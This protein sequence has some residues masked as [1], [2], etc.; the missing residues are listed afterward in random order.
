MDA[1]WSL[2]WDDRFREY[3]FGPDHPFTQES[4]WLA[5]RLMEAAGVVGSSPG[6]HSP[7]PR[8]VPIASGAELERFH[9]VAYLDLVEQASHARQ[10]FPL[11]GGDTPSF[12]GCF[13]AAARVAKGTLLA[14]DSVFGEVPQA[15]NP[16]GGLHHAHP[17]RA[18]GFCIFNDLAIAIATQIRH[19]RRRIAYVDID[20]H[21]GDG[22]MYGFYDEGHVLDIDFHQDGRT[23]FPGT[24]TPQETGRGDGAGLKVNVPL[25]PGAG[26][27]TFLTLFRRLVPPLIRS[28]RPEVILL[29]NGVDAHVDDGLAALALTPV[30]YTEVITTMRSLAHEVCHDRLVV[31]GGGGYTA[32]NVSRVLAR[33]GR[34]LAGEAIAPGERKDLP[35]GWRKEFETTLGTRA[36]LEWEDRVAPTRPP[37][38]PQQIRALVEE[39]EEALGR[40]IPEETPDS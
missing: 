31:T 24:G 6:S 39:L 14:A 18:S 20:A 21:H 16:A 7:S 5:V 28:F 33:V 12:P 8:S 11:D 1:K 40:P 17:D 3:A 22:V 13:D 36:P 10:S 9:E 29:Q 27:D 19:H 23:I 15:F 38:T 37:W 2:I 30:S 34:V 26:D 4:R 32:E 35:L 25:P